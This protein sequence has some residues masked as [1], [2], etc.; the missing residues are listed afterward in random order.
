MENPFFVETKV[1]NTN[2][3]EAMNSVA[4]DHFQG[5]MKT[6]RRKAQVAEM[7][8]MLARYDISDARKGWLRAFSGV[9]NVIWQIKA[10]PRPPPTGLLSPELR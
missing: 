1:L 2:I 8:S 4:L 3:F 7:E 9:R 6:E 5:R 10:W